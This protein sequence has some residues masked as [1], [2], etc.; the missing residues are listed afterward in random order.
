VNFVMVC[1]VP[2]PSLA[3]TYARRY[4]IKNVTNSYIEREAD[5][6]RFGQLGCQ[7]FIMFNGDGRVHIDATM[8]FLDVDTKAFHDVEFQL[9]FLLS[10][11]Q[12]RPSLEGQMVELVR[13][14]N[15]RRLNGKVGV[16]SGFDSKEQRYQVRVGGGSKSQGVRPVNI[17]PLGGMGLE[18]AQKKQKVGGACG[19]CT[20]IQNNTCETSV[21][22]PENACS[23]NNNQNNFDCQG[24]NCSGPTPKPSLLEIESVGVAEMDDEHDECIQALENVINSRDHDVFSQNLLK[25]KEVISEHFAHEEALFVETGFD[26]GGKFSKTKSH[27]EDHGKI[28]QS[29]D[30]ELNRCLRIKEEGKESG[31]VLSE[32]FVSSILSRLVQHTARY[33]SQYSDHMKRY[34][35]EKVK[36]EG[37]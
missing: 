8:R 35:E 25:A 23:E 31:K 5:M 1:V 3:V 7:G 4:R 6:P 36:E 17:V 11:T 33:D 24:S 20:P 2:G 9:R 19:T 27:R 21:K 12:T 34:F 28:L 13:L 14:V 37:E 22:Q 18:R 16:V 32:D 29:I 30:N 15:A 10:Q 26:D